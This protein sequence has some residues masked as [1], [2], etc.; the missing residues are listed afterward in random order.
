M[1]PLMVTAAKAQIRMNKTTEW[2]TTEW[3]TTE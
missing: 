3:Q 2:Q 1:E